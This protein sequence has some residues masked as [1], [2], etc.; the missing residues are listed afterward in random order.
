[1]R[2]RSIVIPLTFSHIPVATSYKILSHLGQVL[3]VQPTLLPFLDEGIKH[4]GQRNA[5][6]KS[7][8]DAPFASGK[9]H[10]MADLIQ[11]AMLCFRA[12]M[13]F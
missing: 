13:D 3:F 1:V 9:K 10:F 5:D 7:P 6:E 4:D 8:H 12:G 11:K 2:L